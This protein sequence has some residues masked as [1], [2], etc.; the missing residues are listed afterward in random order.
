ML[1]FSNFFKSAAL[2][3]S[4]S[5]GCFTAGFGRSLWR[6]LQS[7]SSRSF[8]SKRNQLMGVRWWYVVG[9]SDL[10]VIST[11][12]SD[13]RPPGTGWRGRVSTLSATS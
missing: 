12:L 13:G 4:C 2:R 1:T 10:L 8:G 11:S 7:V 6:S 5:T 9:L 3:S